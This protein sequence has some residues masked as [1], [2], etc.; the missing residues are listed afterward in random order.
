MLKDFRDLFEE[1][2]FLSKFSIALGSVGIVLAM[3]SLICLP[4]IKKFDLDPAYRN[5]KQLE[6]RVIK[7]NFREKLSSGLLEGTS[8]YGHYY[9]VVESNEGEVYGFPYKGKGAIRADIRYDVGDNIKWKKGFKPGYREG[10]SMPG[11]EY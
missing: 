5:A 8:S 2:D 9:M 3:S 7:E 1:M 6:G 10:F 11:G 4:L